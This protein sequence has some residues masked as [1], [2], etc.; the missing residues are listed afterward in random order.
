MLTYRMKA[1]V[2]W[3]EDDTDVPAEHY[4]DIW[5]LTHRV[6]MMHNSGGC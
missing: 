2:N 4:D 3:N 5:G 1:F 6:F